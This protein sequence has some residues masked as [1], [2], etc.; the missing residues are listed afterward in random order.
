M[1]HTVHDDDRKKDQQLYRKYRPR[2]IK[3][4]IGNEAIVEDIR[5]FAKMKTGRPHAYMLHGPPGCGKTTCGRILGK[6]LG[7]ARHSNDFLELDTASYSGIDAIKKLCY[8]A[9]LYPRGRARVFLLDEAHNLS[10]KAQEALLKLFEEPPPKTFLILCTT[11]PGKI[12]EPLR[13][14]CIIFQVQPLSDEGALDLI[15]RVCRKEGKN[16]PEDVKKEIIER[17]KGIPREIL[18]HLERTFLRY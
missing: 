3:T 1:W 6:K 10:P 13:Q 9:R 4:I 14:R 7:P 12:I 8:I 18:Q 2:S 15:E 17:S 16:I 11:K 5:K